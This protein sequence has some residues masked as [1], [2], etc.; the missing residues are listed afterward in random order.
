MRRLKPPPKK[1]NVQKPKQ[2]SSKND[3]KSSTNRKTNGKERPKVEEEIPEEE[4]DEDEED[5][6]NYIFPCGRWLAKGEDDGQI[7]RELIPYD[8]TGTYARK[9]TLIGDYV[10]L[11]S[12]I[13]LNDTESNLS[14]GTELIGRLQ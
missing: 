12:S 1:E 8:A 9:N 13:L 11:S 14:N 10:T 5:D 6:C 4:M 7:V 3:R 2:K